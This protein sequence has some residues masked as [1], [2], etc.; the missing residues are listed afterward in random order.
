MC[1]FV[2]SH[3]TAPHTPNLCVCML[4]VAAVLS[5]S[6]GFALVY[7]LPV[8][9]MTS[10]FHIMSHYA[11]LNGKRRAYITAKTLLHRFQTNFAQRIK[12]TTNRRRLR[13]AGMK[14]AIYDCIVVKVTLPVTAVCSVISVETRHQRRDPHPSSSSRRPWYSCWRGW[15]RRR[16]LTTGSWLA[17]RLIGFRTNNNNNNT[18]SPATMGV[19]DQY[20]GQPAAIGSTD[21][22]NH[23]FP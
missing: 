21:S 9:W 3:I 19:A 8:L 23:L 12:T 20:I 17:S 22:G 4:T 18:V 6:G 7:V 5:S 15:R 14:Y 11:F 13:L 10:S 16:R 1:L 2:H